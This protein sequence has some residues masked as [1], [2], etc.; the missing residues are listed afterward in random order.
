M[1]ST[2]LGRI[3]AHYYIT[4]ETIETFLSQEAAV[5]LMPNMN[6]DQILALICSSSEFSQIQVPIYSNETK[7]FII[8]SAA[9]KKWLIWTSWSHWVAYIRSV[10][11]VWL[12]LKERQIAFSKATSRVLSSATQLCPPK[13]I[14]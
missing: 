9:N 6:D 8:F 5:K 4:Y 2:D 11:E 10:A 13:P 1:Y 12:P 7:N 14:M 3:A